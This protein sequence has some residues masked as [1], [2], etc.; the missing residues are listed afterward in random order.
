[1]SAP[2]PVFLNKPDKVVFWTWNEVT[3][4]LGTLLFVWLTASFLLGLA[5]SIGMVKLLR[6]LQKSS[7]GDLTKVGPYWFLPSRK[8]FKFLP[9]SDIREY[10]G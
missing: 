2:I 9:P 10:L 4:F 8:S 1:M 7:L 5:L 3:W 6:V